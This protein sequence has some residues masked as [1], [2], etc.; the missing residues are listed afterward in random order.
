V[1]WIFFDSRGLR[2]YFDTPYRFTI[3]ADEASPVSPSYVLSPR[4]SAA[5][6]LRFRGYA[7]SGESPERRRSLPH[8]QIY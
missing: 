7:A 2:A 4:P 3:S 6:F 5:A 1:W 8:R